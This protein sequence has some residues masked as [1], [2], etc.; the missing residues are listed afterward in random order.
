MKISYILKS[1]ALSIPIGI[2]FVD[3]VGY[4]A[5]VEG[6]IILSASCLHNNKNKVIQI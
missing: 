5:R 6:K 1:V 4:I 2:T 3:C